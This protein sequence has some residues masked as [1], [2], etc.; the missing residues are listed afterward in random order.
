MYSTDYTRQCHRLG[1]E[2]GRRRLHLLFRSG[3]TVGLTATLRQTCLLL[4]IASGFAWSGKSRLP[5][6]VGHGRS[7]TV[8]MSVER[9]VILGETTTRTSRTT[10]QRPAGCRP[11]RTV[12]GRKKTMK[13]LEPTIMCNTT[14]C[15]TE[16]RVFQM[17]FNLTH[18]R[19]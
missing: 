12:M 6:A 13:A 15:R 16:Y 11:I 7:P 18:R 17:V 8:H 5:A 9:D 14:L 19:E 10:T 2:T 4:S 3:A 1:L